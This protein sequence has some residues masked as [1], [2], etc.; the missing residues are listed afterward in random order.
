MTV[1]PAVATADNSNVVALVID[2]IVAPAGTP[3]PATSIPAKRVA[4]LATVTVASALTVVLE[5]V[6]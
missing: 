1:A 2:A 5:S 6:N 4:V 3:A